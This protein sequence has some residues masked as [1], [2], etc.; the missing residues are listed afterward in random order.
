MITDEQVREAATEYATH[1]KD[2]TCKGKHFNDDKF[3][4][5]ISGHKLASEKYQSEI[6]TLKNIF[7]WQVEQDGKVTRHSSIGEIEELQ[8]KLNDYESGMKGA[9][10]TCEIV[11]I[12]NIELE[13]KL[14]DK[15]KS[16]TFVL[17]ELEKR[18]A[19]TLRL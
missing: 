5:F 9:C 18:M 11:A 14:A 15:E 13:K 12:N 17:D 10:S 8:K 16:L 19:K 4:G 3:Q 6:E 1:K 7:H 2:C